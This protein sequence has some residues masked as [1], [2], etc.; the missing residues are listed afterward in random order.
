[1]KKI[2]L[3]LAV[4]LFLPVTMLTSCQSAATKAE[5]SGDKVQDA[6]ENV[7]EAKQ[8][9]NQALI[10]S[11]MLFRKIS[12]E[13]ISKNEKTIAEFRVKIA[14]ERKENRVRYEKNLAV[15]EQKNLDL[16]KKLAEYKEERNQDWNEFR[17]EFNHDMDELGKAFDD[18]TVNNVK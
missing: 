2:I 18:L 14:K 1:M 5:N 11:V 16:K 10:D 6:R 17:T 4:A 12:D 3:K 7:A 15:L 13:K 8:E 9:L